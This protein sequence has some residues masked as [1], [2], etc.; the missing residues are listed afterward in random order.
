MT[1]IATVIAAIVLAAATATTV[2]TLETRAEQPK[3]DLISYQSEP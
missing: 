2:V 3:R 1:T